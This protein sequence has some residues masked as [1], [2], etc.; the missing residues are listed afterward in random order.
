MNGGVRLQER[1]HFQFSY[2]ENGDSNGMPVITLEVMSDSSNIELCPDGNSSDAP[3][4]APDVDSHHPAVHFLTIK[5]CH[6]EDISDNENLDDKEQEAN[7]NSKSRNELLEYMTRNDGSV[8]CKLCG[9]ILQSRTH[10]YRHKY[11]RHVIQPLNP[12]PLFQCE[13]CLVFFKSRKGYIGHLSS[14][15]SEILTDPSPVITR[16]VSEVPEKLPMSPVVVKREPEAEA[17]PSPAHPACQ[18]PVK[19]TS[20]KTESKRLNKVNKDNRNKEDWEEKRYREEK[21]VADIIDRVKRE[22]EAQ[23]GNSGARR[24]YTRRTTVM[25]T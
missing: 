24:G 23:G 22:C 13:Q 7:E 8:V 6:S 12:A 9:E 10:W 14:R 18:A 17:A 21:L 4:S 11:K 3:S 25:H 1:R 2:E 15:H 19:Q 20:T 5:K 16:T